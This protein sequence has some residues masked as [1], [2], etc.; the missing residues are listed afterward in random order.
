MNRPMIAQFDGLNLSII[1]HAGKKWLTAE[2][3]GLALGYAPDKSRQG[4]NNLYKRH[5][6]EFTEQDSTVINLMTV[7]NKMRE[8]RI[9]SGTGCNLLSF[10]SNT[11]RAK[12]FRAWAKQVLAEKLQAAPVVLN[13]PGKKLLVTRRLERQVL[14]LFVQGFRQKEIAR[15]T[16]LSVATV[17]LLLHAK[18]QF[19]PAAGRPECSTE[20]LAMVANRHFEVEQERLIDAQQRLAQRLCHHSHNKA[21]A[22]QLDRVGQHLQQQPAL[23]LLPAVTQEV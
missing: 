5:D 14:E 11:P 2:Q 6:D 21:L 17:N 7:D 1:D 9:F 19:S 22:E 4:I 10:F 12:E 16:G 18:Y 23:S 13:R 8:A 15:E 20:L 3:V